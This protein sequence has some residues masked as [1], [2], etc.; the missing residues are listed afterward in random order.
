[1]THHNVFDTNPATTN[2]VHTITKAHSSLRATIV[3][4]SPLIHHD[5][6]NNT[7]AERLLA[8]APA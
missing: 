8:T 5:R 6:P 1:M 2:N 4:N 3:G 7:A